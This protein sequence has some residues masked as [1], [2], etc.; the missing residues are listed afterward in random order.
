MAEADLNWWTFFTF[1]MWTQTR[2]LYSSGSAIELFKEK[3]Y[4]IVK[5]MISHASFPPF[6]QK[7]LLTH[8]LLVTVVSAELVFQVHGCCGLCCATCLL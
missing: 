2:N 6:A 4:Y 8:L 1:I 5:L 3:R 7:A